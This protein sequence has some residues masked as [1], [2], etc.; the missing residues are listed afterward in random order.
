MQEL[1]I[2]V[3]TFCIVINSWLKIVPGKTKLQDCIQSLQHRI[4]DSRENRSFKGKEVVREQS[5][6]SI[7]SSYNFQWKLGQ[8]PEWFW[9]MDMGIKATRPKEPS[10][11]KWILGTTTTISYQVEKT[12]IVESNKILKI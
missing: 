5:F 1:S 8:Q 11:K 12:Q 2:K 6:D 10:W 7:C 3:H 9:N 4:Q